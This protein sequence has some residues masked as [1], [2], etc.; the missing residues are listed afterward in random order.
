VSDRVGSYDAA[1]TG[2]AGASAGD[3]P[4]QRAFFIGGLQTVR[5][6][7]ARTAGEGRIGDSF[8]MSRVETGPRSPGFR[9]VFFYDIGWAGRRSDFTHAVTPLQ[10]AG[11]GLSLLDG[12]FR[13]DASRGIWPERSW[14]WDV[15]LGSRF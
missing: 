8:W 7:Y 13:I 4:I 1:L 5:G 12:M 9:P 11:V 3:L 15:Y 14:R 2:A 10:G 6:Q